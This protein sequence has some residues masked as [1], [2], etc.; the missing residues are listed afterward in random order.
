AA[1]VDRTRGE[2]LRTA[3][4]YRF[5]G[6]VYCFM[7]DHF[8]GLFETMASTC[9][10][11]KFANMFKQRSAF[12][13]KSAAGDKLWQDGYFDRVLRR[14]ETTLDVIAYILDNPIRASLCSD[15]REYPYTGS[16][17]YSIDVLWEAIA[18]RFVTWRPDGEATLKGSPYT[19]WRG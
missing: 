6:I 9:D 13:H 18:G 11:R 16:T 2:L 5:A 7:P 8:H 10:F 4:D 15:P 3:V 19:D 1:C 14:E 12:A 17:L